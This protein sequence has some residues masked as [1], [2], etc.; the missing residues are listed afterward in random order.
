[1]DQNIQNIN[2]NCYRLN[3]LLLEMFVDHNTYDIPCQI[4]GLSIRP[5]SW[6][7]F[8]GEPPQDSPYVAHIYW[9]VNYEFGNTPEGCKPDLKVSV[10][11][12][13][14][15]WRVKEELNLLKHEYG[16]YLIGCL[17]G[18]AFIKRSNYDQ[19]KDVKSSYG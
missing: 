12:R 9:S 6:S 8:Q 18:L 17:C 2:S 15:S 19:I 5:L 16:H 4:A 14:K 11:V 3:I 13:P 1:M 7:D 10:K